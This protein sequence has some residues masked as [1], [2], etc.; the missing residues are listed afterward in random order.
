MGGELLDR[1]GGCV[2]TKT[3]ITTTTTTTT[4]STNINKLEDVSNGTSTNELGCSGDQI[5]FEGGCYQLAT[6]GPCQPGHW[7]LLVGVNTLTASI[8]FSVEVVDKQVVDKQVVDKQDI[9]KQ[10]IAECKP[11]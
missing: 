5:P 9:G 11:R 6:T 2:T 3:T 8:T 4:T 10:V 7:L 1:T